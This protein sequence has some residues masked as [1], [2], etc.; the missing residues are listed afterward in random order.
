VTEL[1]D[2]KKMCTKF[3]ITNWM[4]VDKPSPS[5]S[6]DKTYSWG[7]EHDLAI[8]AAPKESPSLVTFGSTAH[9]KMVK[10]KTK[11]FALGFPVYQNFESWRLNY[12]G[13]ADLL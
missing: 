10:E 12:G 6:L 1:S 9:M 3:P 8:L 7:I 13:G 4:R 11:M 2:F 5:A